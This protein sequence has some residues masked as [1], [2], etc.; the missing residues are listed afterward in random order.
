VLTAISSVCAGQREKATLA[1]AT[2]DAEGEALYRD[3]DH[4]D[5]LVM[6]AD[7]IQRGEGT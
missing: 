6:M 4:L 7:A 3:D 1:V 5:E 2:W